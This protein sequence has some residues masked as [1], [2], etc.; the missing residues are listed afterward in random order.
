MS[1][2]KKLI[3]NNGKLRIRFTYRGYRF[4]LGKLGDSS[5]EIARCN[6]ESIRLRICCD[7]ASNNFSPETNTELALKYNPSSVNILKA[8]KPTTPKLTGKEKLTDELRSRLGVKFNSNFKTVLNL[9][10]EYP[11]EI[12]AETDAKSFLVWVKQTR[13]CT[14]A[15]QHRYLVVLQSLSP[16]FDGIRV[17]VEQK[18][19]PKPFTKDEVSQILDWFNSH[20][21][22]NHYHDFILFALNTG[23]RN[24]EIIGLQWKHVDFDQN[25]IYFY[26]SLGRTENS[27]RRSD[28]KPTKTGIM[29]QFPLANGLLT[30]LKGRYERS[31]KNPDDLVFPSPEGKAIDD[32]NF[33]RRIWKKCLTEL[34]IPYRR[35][36]NCRHTFISHMLV[37][38]GDAVKVANL[39]HNSRSG[40]QTIFRSYVGLICNQNIPELYC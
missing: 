31:N 6:A 14:N 19:L 3:E 37:K 7:I 17:K 15:T 22:Y 8:D 36:Y 27:T 10:N 34:K 2:P 13:K 5:N 35:L 20:K 25:I 11:K 26:E 16:L 24:G 18:P 38:T 39:T 1:A 4:D 21:L 40:V 33:S 32:C 29:R 9:I 28:R 12:E 23:A 30:M